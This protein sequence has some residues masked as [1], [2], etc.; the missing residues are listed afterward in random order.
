MLGMT[1]ID[2][3]S[4]AHAANS[5]KPLSVGDQPTHAIYGFLRTLRTAAFT[6]AQ[7]TPV[8][9]WDG[10]SWRHTL[11]PDYKS[12]RNK[13]PETK[14]EVAQAENKALLKSQKAYIRKALKHLGVRQ[15]A[16]FNLE[17]D[18]P[19]G[20]IVRKNAGRQRIML[21]SGDKDW[22][23]LVGQGVT[24]Y[25]PIRDLH[26]SERTIEAKLGVKSPK[27]WLECKALMGATSGLRRTG[28]AAIDLAWVAAGRFDGFVEHDLKPWDLAAGLILVREA[29]GYVSDI[30]GAQG[31][32]EAG[33]VVAG[34][35]TIHRALLTTLNGVSKDAGEKNSVSA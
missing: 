21:I 20:L 13:P 8:V 15:I 23:Q 12:S 25:D 28:A 33:S 4:I 18:D 19:A 3:M 1:L 30:N 26:I 2:G 35:Q 14:Y 31:M 29:G 32:L 9:L 7:L 5:T 10:A 22:I 27:V 24:W 17:A 11:F 6:Y 16:A 34:N